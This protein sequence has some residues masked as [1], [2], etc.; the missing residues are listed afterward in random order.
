MCLGAIAM[1][2]EAWDE[3]GARRQARRRLRRLAR[4]RTRRPDR[5]AAARPPRR[6]GRGPR[7]RRCRPRAC[8]SCCP[9]RPGRSSMTTIP[10]SL[11]LR[12]P[13][14]TVGIALAFV[15]ACVSG[16]AVYVNAKGWRG[17][18]TRPSTPPRRTPSPG[19]YC[20]SSRCLCWR[21]RARRGA[22]LLGHVRGATGSVSSRSPALAAASR[23]SSSSKGSHARTQPKPRSSTRRS[24]SGSHS[25]RSLL[26]ERLGPAHVGAIGLLMA[27]Q[28]WL[29]GELGVVTF[30]AGS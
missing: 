11:E 15:T 12:F 14:R 3:D 21:H 28:V 8:A 27:G 19:L 6:A 5:L 24:S 16:V 26:R 22:E 25:W 18:T 17:S 23:S 2:V 10:A 20:F 4:V 1:L 29:V 7:R 30:G 13:A 9:G